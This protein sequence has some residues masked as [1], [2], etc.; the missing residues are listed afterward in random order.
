MHFRIIYCELKESE[1]DSF[2]YFMIDYENT[3]NLIKDLKKS[4][5]ICSCID[6]L[7]KNVD[8]DVFV[9]SQYSYDELKKL[10]IDVYRLSP[11]LGLPE[12][13]GLYEVF[14]YCFDSCD[15]VLSKDEIIDV[16]TSSVLTDITDMQYIYCVFFKNKN[17]YS[18][19]WFYIHNDS[20]ITILGNSSLVIDDC[21]KEEYL[22]GKYI[23]SLRY[24]MALSGC[25]I[26]HIKFL[27]WNSS[28]VNDTVLRYLRS[29]CYLED[30]FN[31]VEGI[32]SLSYFNIINLLSNDLKHSY[33]FSSDEFV[34]ALS[35]SSVKLGL[36]SSDKDNS[37]LC[38]NSFYKDYSVCISSSIE[39]Q[40]AK[41]GIILDCEGNK[42]N[43]SGLRELGGII[44]CRSNDILL[45]VET[46]KCTEILLEET[47]TQAIKN[48]ELD[49]GR[50]IPARGI[51]VYTYGNYDEVMIED[52]LRSISNKQFRKRIKKVFKYH[53]CR[54]YIYNYLDDSRVSL[55]EKKTLSNVASRLGVKVVTPK[56]DALA[57]SRT[58]FNVLTFILRDTGYWV[59]D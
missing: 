35:Q 39:K 52:S 38:T 27:T 16:I 11:F 30:L 4:S 42:N 56:H 24:K 10:D 29:V 36:K 47:L 48:Y 5:G 37:L 41:W 21:N 7:I 13:V 45:L 57:D 20:S 59:D 51:D 32:N 18:F 1:N 53:D 58:L 40:R 26:N 15:I 8:G 28:C 2:T 50:Y 55:D 31:S 12:N 22:F 23:K 17:M 19:S 34:K 3:G 9:F 44:F 49:I 46:F 54:E 14:S 33:K 25:C 43:K 6:N